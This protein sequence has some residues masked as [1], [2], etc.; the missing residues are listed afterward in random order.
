[1]NR[2]KTI[3]KEDKLKT[4][5][6]ILWL[7][8][9]F[10]SFWGSD[11]LAIP[12][13]AVGQLYPFRVLLPVTAVVFV[14]WS[15][16]EK[17]NPWKDSGLLEKLCYG[18]IGILLVYGAISLAF[19]I[20]VSFTLRRLFNLFFDLCFFFLTMRLCRDSA[21]LK[22]TLTV[23]TISVILLCVAGVFE[24]FCGG[25][26]NDSYDNFKRLTLFNN[27]YQYPIVIAPNT[28]DFAAILV[29]A[30]AAI[31]LQWG[32]SYM[33]GKRQL[34]I[35][36][37]IVPLG[38]FLVTCSSS[39]LAIAAMWILFAGLALFFLFASGKR[40]WV[41]LLVLVL[42]FGVNFANRYHYVMPAI[43]SYIQDIMNS[44]SDPNSA[45]PKLDLS[46]PD[47][48]PLEDELLD[49]DEFGNVI[50]NNNH[51]GGVRI[52]LILHAADCF[53]DSWGMGV[54]LGNTEQLAK[55]GVADENGGIW[56]IH[57]FLARII[58][59]YGIWALV[60]LLTIVFV[61]LKNVIQAALC[62]TKKRDKAFFGFLLLFLTVFVIYPI[63]STTSSDA[64]DI[65]AMWLYLGFVVL[66]SNSLQNSDTK[67]NDNWSGIEI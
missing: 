3:W 6:H 33:Q 21:L 36:L 55:T 38:F 61:L 50:I 67:L 12:F 53:K 39:R 22:K 62:E 26:F 16:R 54:G 20:D 24:I 46:N 32:R 56:S 23:I 42:F 48:I 40:L 63:N 5:L 45:P 51:S 8:T 64:Q 4:A 14:V 17:C 25:I 2:L 28:N 43:N 30:L 66:F 10:T 58:G 7:L 19:A 59:D 49:R 52:G 35:P 47:D 11:L 37:I 65:L 27:I 57:C 44:L 13:P 31:L 60:P 9:V 18:L 15:V 29:F 34:W 1:M 41:P